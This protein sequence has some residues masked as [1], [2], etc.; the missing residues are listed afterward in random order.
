M[1]CFE[2]NL[3]KNFTIKV[4]LKYAV[5][6]EIKQNCLNKN[7][8]VDILFGLFKGKH[9]FYGFINKIVAKISFLKTKCFDLLI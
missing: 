5:W 8:S 1:N 3:F 6:N 9:K 2:N 7:A 4:R